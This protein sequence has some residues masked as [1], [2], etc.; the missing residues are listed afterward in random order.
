MKDPI[1]SKFIQRPATK[2]GWW[3]GALAIFAMLLVGVNSLELNPFI[4]TIPNEPS[5]LVLVYDLTMFV[6]LMASIVLG[7]IAL[8]RKREHSWMVWLFMIPVLFFLVALVWLLF[9]RLMYSSRV[10]TAPT[11]DANI[12]RILVIFD[13][14]G[15]PDGTSAL[16]F[17]LSEPR[18]EVKVVSV[19]YGESHPQVYIQYLGWML[20]RYG[21]GNLPLGAGKDSPLEGDNKFPDSVREAANGFWGFAP[22]SKEQVFKV[23]ESPELIIKTIMESDKPV[24]VFI[25]GALTNLAQALRLEP[26]IRENIEAVYIMGGAVHVPGNLNDLL[27]N[28]GNIVAEWN[29]YIDP[30]AASEV[31]ASGLNLRLVPLDATNQVNLSRQD[32]VVWRKGG[33]IPDFA[34]DIYDSLMGAWG[35]DEIEMWDLMTAEIMLNPGHCT[36]T[37]LRL[38]VMTDEGNMQGQTRVMEG[39]T[40]VDVCLEPDSN[41]IK[42]MLEEVFSSRK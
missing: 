21:Y 9:E 4:Q 1:K 16:L 13:D 23:D 28:T 39:E 27:P 31:F 15:S 10:E 6:S 18:A 12:E 38:E 34:A 42:Q 36:F 11:P 32:T 37:P 40:N 14:D 30:L 26:D 7:V 22:A 2:T 33:S 17:L 19:S 8:T 25:S 35:E 41:A 29:I 3:A 20:K 5:I 24:T